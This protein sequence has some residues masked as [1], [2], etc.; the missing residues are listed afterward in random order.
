MSYKKFASRGPKSKQT[1]VSELVRNT[2]RAVSAAGREDWPLAA[3]LWQSV[4]KLAGREAP[5]EAY[6]N[7][8]RCLRQMSQFIEAEQLLAA[9]PEP[10]ALAVR[11]ELAEI[12]SA[13]HDWPTAIQRWQAVLNVFGAEVNEI[14]YVRL[15][16]A[17]AQ[18]GN[19]GQAEQIAEQ[20]LKIFPDNAAAHVAKA[21]VAMAKKDWLSAAKIWQGILDNP[22]FN[23]APQ[24]LA[25]AASA[26]R[27]AGKLDKAGQVI[28]DGLVEH[29]RRLELLMEQAEIHTTA[30]DWRR[31]LQLWQNILQ[32]FASQPTF[33][34]QHRLLCRF[35]V[36]V[37]KRIINIE[38]YKKD[39]KKYKEARKVSSDKAQRVA[40]YTAVSKGYDS[41]KLPEII[42]PSFDYFC[43][44]DDETMDGYGVYQILPFPVMAHDPGRTIRYPK[45]HPHVLFKDYSVALW[46]DTS[47]M[48]TGDIRPLIDEF[49]HS[50]FDLATTPHPV[51]TSLEEEYA[52]CVNLMKDDPVIMRQQIDNYK[53]EG[54]EVQTFSENGLLLFKPGSIKLARALETWWEQIQ[55]FSK[56][57]QLSFGYSVQK[58]GLKWFPISQKPVNIRNNPDFVLSPHHDEL[59]ALKKLYELLKK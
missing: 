19:F 21:R 54:I 39:I 26:F 50:E 17:L 23:L 31:A 52:A 56:R 40:V 10:D 6:L 9:A 7:L 2:A 30:K 12:A 1:K 37:I 38:A 33:L 8:A 27:Q 22:K 48:I 14:S 43:Y 3:K 16:Y 5:L 28:D 46:L 13:R 36:S 24:L 35:N 51:R 47:I 11:V 44:T 41:L 32:E 59:V 57:D 58:W 15:S 45:T 25:T 20:G 29:G 18:T 4:I 55:K 34:D 42:D 53:K 49:K